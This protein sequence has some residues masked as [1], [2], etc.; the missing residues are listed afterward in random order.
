M[1]ISLSRSERSSLKRFLALYLFF[2]LLVI[3]LTATLYYSSQKEL[4]A[5]KRTVA[6]E[7]YTND[8]MSRLEELQNDATNTLLYPYDEG[9]ETSLY[10][11]DYK[12]IY[13][14][15]KHP[16]SDLTEVTYSPNKIIRYI[17]QP[18]NYYL[19]TRYIV[20]EIADDGVWLYKTLR[21][22]LLYSVLF[23]LF[24]LIVGYFLVRLFL[25]PMRDALL[26]LDTFIKDTTHELNTPVSTILSNIELLKESALQ[27]E[28]Q[29]KIINRID[30][31]AKTI[32]N[33]YDDL[34]YLTLQHKILSHNEPVDLAALCLERLEYFESMMQMKKIRLTHHITPKIT[35]FADKKKLS[36]L[37]DNLLS[38]A[39]KY[40]KIGGNIE[41]TLDSKSLTVYDSGRGIKE[42]DQKSIFKRYERF[43]KSVGGFGIGLNIVKMICDEYAFEI[44]ISSEVEKFTKVTIAF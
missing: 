23:L 38:N 28:T 1:D 27:E 6:L 17:T 9:F 12:I 15:L 44:Q 40:N 36:K 29:K 31:G 24:M 20:V 41:V 37:I 18:Q 42:E 33:I 39:I 7:E 14:T 43:D 22:I 19:Q 11:D 21:S 16:K 30:I 26:L 2:T 10:G 4:A 8:F 35:L 13:S 3:A 5:S 34:T 32:S 25:K